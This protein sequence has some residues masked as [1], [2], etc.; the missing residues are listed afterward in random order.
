MWYMGGDVPKHTHK[1][2]DTITMKESQI[3][4][5]KKKVWYHNDSYNIKKK[6]THTQTQTQ[7]NHNS[8]QITRTSNK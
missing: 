5:T 8:A 7:Q 4:H 6:Q 1:H 3:T 2:T